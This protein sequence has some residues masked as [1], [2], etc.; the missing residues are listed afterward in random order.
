MDN[1][2]TPSYLCPLTYGISTY[3]SQARSSGINTI[4]WMRARLPSTPHSPGSR[5]HTPRSITHSYCHDLMLLCVC[6]CVCQW[7]CVWGAV[8]V[9][10]HMS[11][12][13][14]VCVFFPHLPHTRQSIQWL[15][16]RTRSPWHWSLLSLLIC[17]WSSLAA[18]TH[19]LQSSLRLGDDVARSQSILE[20]SASQVR[21][22]CCYYDRCDHYDH[23]YSCY[24]CC[25]SVVTDFYRKYCS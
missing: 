20:E 3:M 14:Y 13:V 8:C 18:E 7:V 22:L 17:H 23:C 10:V 1:H 15:Y 21:P 2:D 5:A 6:V 12:C 25:C 11:V 19:F 4:C 24:C 9:C 16:V